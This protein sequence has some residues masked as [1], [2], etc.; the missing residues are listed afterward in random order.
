MKN[1]KKRRSDE[2]YLLLKFILIFNKN[3]LQLSLSLT[4]I[5]CD[6]SL[7]INLLFLVLVLYDLNLVV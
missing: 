7:V 6:I 3:N 4:M 2:A 1:E 5:T